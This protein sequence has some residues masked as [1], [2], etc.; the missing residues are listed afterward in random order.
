V[1]EARLK[2]VPLFESLSRKQLRQVSQYADEIDLPEG[3]RFVD[4]GAFSHEFFVIE[5]GTAEV[6]RDGRPI[7]ELG[8]GDFAGEMGILGREVRNASVVATSPL[9]AIVMLGRD[10]RQLDRSYPDVA[11]Q[12]REAVERRTQSL[13]SR[14]PEPAA[15]ATRRCPR[16][17][18]VR[19]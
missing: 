8:P 16:R 9:T 14:M 15:P 17:V 12:I 4:E 1:D 18:R 10:F 5:D 19:R 7:A 3:T 2:E 6:T 11:A 13:V